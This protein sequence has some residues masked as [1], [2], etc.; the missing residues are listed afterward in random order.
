MDE[1]ERTK[2]QVMAIELVLRDVA[3]LKAVVSALERS[4]ADAEWE[5]LRWA[6][7]AATRNLSKIEV[8]FGVELEV[9]V[10]DVARLELDAQG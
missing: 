5:G 8:D 1:L 6:A 9:G 2:I 3:R 4:A 7:D 10:L